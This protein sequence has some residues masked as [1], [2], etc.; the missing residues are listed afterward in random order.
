MI[1]LETLAAPQRRALDLI[2]EVAAEKNLRP[3]L[4]GGPVRDLLLG[5]AV[6]D[7]DFTLEN[8]SSALAR[9]IGKLINGRVRSYPQFLTYKV[10]AD[11]FPEIDIAT[12]RSEKY[13][14]PGALPAVSPGSLIDD[15]TRRDFSI[16][17]IALDVISGEIHDPAGG[18]P[19][20]ENKRIRVLH[21]ASFVDDPTRIFRAIRLATRLGFAID[22][23]TQEL[24]D[25]AIESRALETVAKERLWRELALAFEEEKAPEVIEAL[26]RAG[27]LDVL[28]GKRELKR[29]RL[30]VAQQVRRSNPSLD[31][32][33]LFLS[34]ILY[35]D[36]SPIDLEG[37][38][39][40][41][42]RVRSVMQIANEIPRYTDALHEAES[43]QDRF[44]VLKH[45]SPELL[46]MLPADHVAKFRDFQKFQIPLRGSDLEVPSGPHIAKAL[47][48]TREAVFT[49]EIRA[50]D[51]RSFAREMAIKYLEKSEN[52]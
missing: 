12:A 19:D 49:G 41:Q 43:D 46:A 7:L 9:G 44:K 2:R 26:N 37:S 29:D 50:D 14:G 24:L 23:H 32:E 22:E 15:L 20:V 52:G 31:A 6:I 34:Q 39:L 35:G 47:E 21:D 5:R 36:A 1:S 25:A 33:V 48:R 11:D 40:S 38:G 13:R 3:F 10:T 42:K 18:L 16:N 45:A 8:E 4:V 30:D 28:F 51:A 27:A 17:A